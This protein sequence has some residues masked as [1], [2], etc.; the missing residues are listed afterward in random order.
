[1]KVKTR[2]LRLAD[3]VKLSGAMIWHTAIV[4]QIEDGKVT[5]FRPYGHSADFSSTGGVIC[6]VGIEQFSVPQDS[7]FEYEVLDRKELK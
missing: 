7:D 4:S 5:F 3:T 2:D 1:M 6:Y